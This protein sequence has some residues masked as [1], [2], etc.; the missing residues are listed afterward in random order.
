M[1]DRDHRD[2]LADIIHA[3][4]LIE[5]FTHGIDRHAFMHD[6]KTVF[7]VIRCLEIIGEAVKRIPQDFR[8][9]HSQIPWKIMAGMR[10]RLIH[11][12]DIVNYEIIWNTIQKDI[13]GIKPDIEQLTNDTY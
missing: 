5:Q 4:D 2:Y 11:G 3:I 13:P 1:S 12:Y 10:D 8:E 9:T 7:A 6:E